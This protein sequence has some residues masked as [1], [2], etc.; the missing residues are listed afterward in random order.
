[1][2]RVQ[3]S[4]L[5][6]KAYFRRYCERHPDKVRAWQQ[7]Y[8]LRHPERIQA[9][10][11]AEYQKRK[12]RHLAGETE[13]WLARS[14]ERCRE[15]RAT[16]VLR[17]T[18][19][20]LAACQHDPTKAWTIRGPKWVACI[21]DGCG[22]LHQ[23]LGPHVKVHRLSVR[24]Y[25]SKPGRIEGVPRYSA[26][27]SLMS[28]DLQARRSKIS[29]K[30]G[31]GRRL[32]KSGKAPPVHRLIAAR[33]KRV[34]SQQCRIV[35]SQRMQGRG[36]PKLW[37]RYRGKRVARVAEDW[38]IAK[39]VADGHSDDEIAS[40][41]GLRHGASVGQRR[42]ALG[43]CHPKKPR[44]YAL[45]E[46]LCGRHVLTACRDLQVSVEELA[47]QMGVRREIVRDCMAPG[48]IDKPL[49]ERIGKKFKFAFFK[50][51]EAFRCR[52][53][54]GKNG[55]RPRLLLASERESL[56]HTYESLLRESKA[57]LNWLHD[58]IGEDS[59]VSFEQLREWVY[60]EARI[61]RLRRIAMW[62]YFFE[63]FRGASKDPRLL[64]GGIT[65]FRLTLDFLADVYAVSIE[66]VRRAV[67][68][69]SG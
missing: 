54:D 43:F 40:K 51:R 66:T 38:E 53:S 30:L 47:L 16:R 41:L 60:L 3:R 44:V 57:I 6:R 61:G 36:N 48:R 58:R 33:G 35:R 45:G 26:N 24:E 39:L 29:K 27:A 28:L 5:D 31:L 37:G 23:Q 68:S 59:Q 7:A 69:T 17:L 9:R 49:S 10:N 19:D 11:R 65:P 8:R 55:G 14:K 2:Q 22:E 63:W 1:M 42:R 32:L 56:P 4:P 52:A 50:L 34:T 13:V 15:W 46:L 64:R 62:P 20:E 12:A 21:E 67:Y 18:P 25:K